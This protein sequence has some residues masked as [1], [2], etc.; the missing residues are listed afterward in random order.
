[1]KDPAKLCS[2]AWC[3]PWMAPA[4]PVPGACTRCG[5]EALEVA[6]VLEYVTPPLRGWSN[7]PGERVASRCRRCP[8]GRLEEEL[9]YKSRA[10]RLRLESDRRRPRVRSS[11]TCDV[12]GAKAPVARW[13]WVV[14]G[15]CRTAVRTLDKMP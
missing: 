15:S 10:G 13:A 8:T 5:G 3:P 6:H 7:N 11:G 12:C 4:G 1:M 9:H 14:C 2:C